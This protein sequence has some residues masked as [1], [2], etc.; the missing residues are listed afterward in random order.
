MFATLVEQLADSDGV[1][2]ATQAELE[3]LLT[4]RAWELMRQLLQDHLDLTGAA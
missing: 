1:F 2:H 3:E 4:T